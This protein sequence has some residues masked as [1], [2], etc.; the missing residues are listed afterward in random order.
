MFTGITTEICAQAWDVI[1]PAI[2]RGYERD[3]LDGFKG[4]VVVLDPADASAEPIFTAHLGDDPAS[5][6]EWATAKAA[7]AARTGMDT[8]RLRDHSPHLYRAGDIKWPGAIVREGVVVAFSG[9]QGEYDEMI[10]EWLVSAIRA[11]CR[12]EFSN[13]DGPSHNGGPFLEG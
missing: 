12:V 10:A 4:G 9:V 1:T 3:I 6:V 13:P 11:I 5:F 7:V 8:S 2:K